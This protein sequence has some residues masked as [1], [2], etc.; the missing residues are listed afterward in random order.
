MNNLNLRFQ[1]ISSLI[2]KEYDEKKH[3]IISRYIQLWNKYKNKIC[4]Y[5]LWI[6]LLIE[7]S[8]IIYISAIKPLYDTITI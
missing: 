8:F 5:F 2:T 6:C 7:F 4:L 3:T 1:N